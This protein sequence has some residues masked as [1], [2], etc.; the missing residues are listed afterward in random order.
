M[1]V[2]NKLL[3]YLKIYNIIYRTKFGINFMNE[4]IENGY[5]IHWYNLHEDIES[6]YLEWLHKNI[7][8]H[9][10]TDPRILWACHFKSLTNVEHPGEKGRLSH[11]N[12]SIPA[13][14]RYILIF[15]SEN[16]RFL[17][18]QQLLNII[19]H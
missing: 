8:Q 6:E 17:Q 5:L 4:I 16:L 10:S 9:V 11:D 1:L 19:N 13:G 15:G 2:T 3:V 14:D 18:I 7:F 12:K